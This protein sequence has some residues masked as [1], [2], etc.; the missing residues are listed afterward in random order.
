MASRA[1]GLADK[2]GNSARDVDRRGLTQI[3]CGSTEREALQLDYGL[4]S[5]SLSRVTR[6]PPPEHPPGGDI[7]A[8]NR[9]RL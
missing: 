2:Q 8:D 3:H 9:S 7:S 5:S 6:P 1:A 4:Y